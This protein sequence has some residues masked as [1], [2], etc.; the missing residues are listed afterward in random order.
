MPSIPIEISSGRTSPG[1][2]LTDLYLW[3]FKRVFEENEL[4]PELYSLVR[5]QLHRGRTDEISLNALMNRW[6]PFFQ[7]QPDPTPEQMEKGK[8]LMDMDEARRRRSIG[9]E[10]A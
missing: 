8:A 9:K 7:N 10:G 6:E 1:L 2:E 5:T 4:A 3:I